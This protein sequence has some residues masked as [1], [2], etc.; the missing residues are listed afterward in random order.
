MTNQGYN[1]FWNEPTLDG[2][3]TGKA[4][5]RNFL[6]KWRAEEFAATLPEHFRPRVF[7]A[8][9]ADEEKIERIEDSENR[10]DTDRLNRR[11]LV[12]LMLEHNITIPAKQ[13]DKWR[14]TQEKTGYIDGVSGGLTIIMTDGLQGYF[15]RPDREP[16]IG[17]V[18]HFH[19]DVPNVSYVPYF[20]EFGEKKFFKQETDSGA[21]PAYF[22]REPKL[23]SNGSSATE[24]KARK[25]RVRKPH[26]PISTAAALDLLK[27][28]TAQLK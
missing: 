21:P 25:P 7:S 8:M 14:P 17:H 24:G 10:D 26:V 4:R 2:L 3:P 12:A 1:V 16:L 18:Q 28:M 13:Y 19:W 11:R 22:K 20:N 6:S 15:L 23:S 9:P 5:R 27:Q